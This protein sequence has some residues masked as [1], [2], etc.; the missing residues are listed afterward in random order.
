MARTRL[1]KAQQNVI[2]L[3]LLLLGVGI[4]VYPDIADW[5]HANRHEQLHQNYNEM[6]A[7]MR[8]EEI[9]YELNRARIFNEGLTGIHVIDPFVPGSG[10]V[11]SAEYYSILNFVD[12]V[13]G[14]IEIPQIGVTLPIFH[15]TSD[16]VL[17]RG[18]GHME[19]T[20]F[21]IGGYGN[22]SIITAHTGMI[23]MRLFTDLYRLDYGSEFFIR[24]LDHTTRYVVDR[25]STV[26]PDEIE[27]LVSYD[28]RD[29]VTLVTC[30][31]Y[32]V[33]TQRLLVRGTRVEYI[34]GGAEEIENVVSPLNLR[35][36][37]VIGFSALFIIILWIYRG[38][39]KE[40]ADEKKLDAQIEQEYEELQR[41]KGYADD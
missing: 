16:E 11:M 1:R 4:L 29:L 14:H 18:A 40:V 12:G 17:G 20:P 37:I 39:K 22:H 31:P 41:R 7:I 2:M 30:T 5:W 6:V 26:Y 21:P 10:S 33:N 13:M 24:V 38:K 27:S 9:E 25:I 8:A 35:L 19:N 3:I 36:V 32:G 28:D 15:G 23:N 34:P